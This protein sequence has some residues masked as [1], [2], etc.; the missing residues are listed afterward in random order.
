MKTPGSTVTPVTNR[1]NVYLIKDIITN[2]DDATKIKEDTTIQKKDIKNVG[3][4]YY[5][6]S[7][8]YTPDWVE[9]FF[10]GSLAEEVNQFSSSSSKGLLIVKSKIKSKT[11]L[12]AIPFGSGRF[13][14]KDNVCEERFGLKASL[15]MLSPDGLKSMG[16]RTLAQNPKISIEQVSKA[17]LASDFEIDIEKD[18]VNSITGN[19]TIADFGKIVTGKDALSV[20][21]KIDITNVVQF[22]NRCYEF[23]NKD[24]YKANFDWIDHIKELKNPTIINKLDIK[25]IDLIEKSSPQVWL[26]PPEIIDW[27]DFSGY[28]YSSR[29]A[30]DIYQELSVD[31]FLNETKM[32]GVLT[33]DDLNKNVVTCWKESKDEFSDRWR[34]YSCLN[35][36]ITIGK[37]VYLLDAGKW[38]EI[39]K[40]FVTLVD[41]ACS[42]IPWVN[43]G[44]PA[45]KHAD[46]NAYN[47]AIAPI[48]SG[49]CLDAKNISHGGGYS[50]IEFCDVISDTKKL[51]YVKKYS[52]SATL[53]HLFAQ[54]YVSGD[55]LLNDLDF[56]Q[57]VIELLPTP[58]KSLIPVTAIVPKD[59]EINYVI[60]AKGKKKVSL[61]FFSKINLKNFYKTLTNYGYKVNLCHIE[62][63]S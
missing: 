36:Q 3:T 62:N 12:F 23:F 40:N 57:K 21:Y 13:I 55:L 15:N 48:I 33:L 51:L 17:G 31:D 2:P 20:S 37:A 4:F 59:Y 38:Y 18:I 32:K 52:G 26:A 6:K 41:I 39:S 42:A 44:L 54:G 34:V 25:L 10:R 9:K 7:R 16:K 22:C 11:K 14:L 50:K 58:A 45:Y 28:K 5:T 8:S 53:S 43:L 1:L 61:P 29:K 60:I 49:Y 30:D 35:A 47:T 46:E 56:R 19:C 63:H 27:T 24:A